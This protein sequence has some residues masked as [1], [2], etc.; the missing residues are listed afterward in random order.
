MLARIELLVLVMKPIVV[1]RNDSTLGCHALVQTTSQVCPS[2]LLLLLSSA[3]R[4]IMRHRCCNADQ[5]FI[6]SLHANCLRKPCPVPDN[7]A[8]R[9]RWSLR[10]VMTPAAWA[11]SAAQS[12]VFAPHHWT[13]QRQAPIVQ[14]P[15]LQERLLPIVLHCWQMPDPTPT[16]QVPI[17]FCVVWYTSCPYAC[18]TGQARQHHGP[19]GHCQRSRFQAS[20]RS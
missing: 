12:S 6:G 5:R 7:R 18:C 19:T 9:R 16:L 10:R 4:C 2:T 17:R 3:L 15:G 13:C 14:A 20:V 8:S 1:V 11:S